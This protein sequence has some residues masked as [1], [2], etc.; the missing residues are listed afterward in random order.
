MSFHIFSPRQEEGGLQDEEQEC[1]AWPALH[2]HHLWRGYLLDTKSNSVNSTLEDKQKEA[3]K[4]CSR[5]MNISVS[6]PPHSSQLLKIEFKYMWT[7]NINLL[8]S[9]ECTETCFVLLEA[10]ASLVVTFS[11]SHSLSQSQTFC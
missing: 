7:K 11:L 8:K 5:W 10:I 2:C 1:G 3:K 4:K 6:V 9:L